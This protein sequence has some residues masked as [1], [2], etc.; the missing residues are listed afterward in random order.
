MRRRMLGPALIGAGVFLIVLAIALPTMVYPRLA[1]LPLNPD[2]KKTARG[3][4]FDVI[5]PRNVDDGGTRILR[6]VGVEATVYVSAA[7]DGPSEDSDVATWRVSTS[8]NIVGHGLLQVTVEGVSL[9]RRTAEP[10]NCCGAD[11]LITEAGDDTGEP[12]PHRGY[13]QQ[14]PFGVQ[15]QTYEMWDANIKGTAAATFVREEDR[16]GFAAYRFQQEVPDQKVGERELPGEL[17]GL[18]DDSVVSDEM[19]RTRRTFW[20]EPNSGAMIDYVESMDRRFRYDGT[21]IPMIQGTLGLG[22]PAPGDEMTKLLE[23]AAFGLP[24]VKWK[25]PWTL[26]PFG[27]VLLAVGIVLTRRARQDEYDDDWDDDLDGSRPG[28]QQ[29]SWTSV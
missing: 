12:M 24:L 8:T 11:Y 23:T 2:V 22:A 20:V 15:K 25:L 18:K 1:T 3:E 16:H 29:P 7:P 5:L 10:V 27:L 13:V 9:D 26:G 4:G 17:F 21:E 14:F 28:A 6:N 19:Y